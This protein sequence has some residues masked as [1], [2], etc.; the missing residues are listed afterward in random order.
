[1][2]HSRAHARISEGLWLRAP[3]SANSAL[4]AVFLALSLA[5]CAGPAVPSEYRE[6]KLKAGVEKVV[7]VDG[8][9]LHVWDKGTGPAVVLLHGLGGSNYDW[10]LVFDPIADAGFRVVAIEMLGAGYSEKPDEADWSLEANARRTG[11]VLDAL[12]IA[13]AHFIG[14]SYGGALALGI[15]IEAPDRVDRLVV[16]D[17]ACMPQEIPFHVDFLRWPLLPNLLMAITPKSWL[18]RMG[19][20]EIVYDYDAVPDEV[21][22]EYAHELGFSGAP[23]ALIE[24]ARAIEIDRAHEYA[25]RYRAIR[26]PTLILWGDDDAV[27]PVRCGKWLR[28][29][30]PG[31]K[32]VIFPRCGHIP[33]AE[34]PRETLEVVL[35]FLRAE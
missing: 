19:L 12:G 4:S 23:R 24:T 11:K 35:P 7:V 20:K 21:V 5:G 31:A 15:A 3:R 14:N 2:V 30:I 18:I 25:K 33:H 8:F 17:P 16:I 32:M 28:E 26:A 29:E 13:K 6:A 34:Y 1:V 9:K 27:T 10:R 22:D